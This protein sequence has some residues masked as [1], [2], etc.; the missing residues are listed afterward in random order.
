MFTTTAIYVGAAFIATVMAT[1]AYRVYAPNIKGFLGERK[2]NN[3]LKDLQKQ[4]VGKLINNLSLLKRDGQ[5]SQLDHVF[6][7]RSGI[8]V[9]E[10]KNYSGEIIGK[11]TDGSWSHIVGDKVYTE[12]NFARQNRGHI[13]ALQ[14]ILEQ[15]PNLPVFSMLSFNPDCNVNLKLIKTIATN[16]NTLNNAIRI[17]SR[18]PVISNEQVNELYEILTS[19]KEK[20]KSV[21]K[22]HVVRVKLQKKHDDRAHRMGMSR[23]EYDK[24]LVEKYKYQSTISLDMTKGRKSSFTDMVNDAS[25]RSGNR[26]LEDKYLNMNNTKERR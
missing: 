17:R 6:I 15:Y 26:S 11:E 5:S 7:N 16:Y 1:V 25:S 4:G 13:E 2:V 14:P 12:K 20:N 21:S 23:E 3:I 22:T 18:F 9:V 10:T 24:N 8:F 19:E